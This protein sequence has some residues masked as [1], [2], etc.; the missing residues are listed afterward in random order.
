M[1]IENDEI[2]SA[3]SLVKTLFTTKM[4]TNDFAVYFKIMHFSKNDFHVHNNLLSE[5]VYNNYDTVNISPSQET[6]VVWQTNIHNFKKY[7]TGLLNISEETKRD[8]KSENV[9]ESEIID[10][11][12]KN[13][14]VIEELAPKMEEH[15]KLA[16]LQYETFLK[17]I[18][19]VQQK[20]DRLSM[21]L[22][23]KGKDLDEATEKLNGSTA[24]FIS[25]LG[26]YSAL[27]F[28]VFGGFDA[29]KSIFSNMRQTPI[30]VILVDGSVL[31]IGLVTLVFILLQSIGILSG[32][33]YLACG[34]K[35]TFECNCSFSKRYPIFSLTLKIFFGILLFGS[36]VHILN[37]TGFL[38]QSN[39]RILL[40]ILGIAL[41]IYLVFNIVKTTKYIKS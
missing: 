1:A 9:E 10:K 6:D 17:K 16:L 37:R 36:I 26:I 30:S 38:Y 4:R 32:K 41:L 14:E 8:N 15:I 29:F 31:M 27:I 22:D 3:E 12:L 23:D 13:R 24:N 40:S 25:I 19:D 21:E 33:A 2:L 11:L 39:L 28:G 34:H 20:A 35:N 7:L 18:D 5:Y